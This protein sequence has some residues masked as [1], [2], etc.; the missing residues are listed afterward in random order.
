MCRVWGR[1]FFLFALIFV[2]LSPKGVLAYPSTF[3]GWYTEDNGRKIEPQGSKDSACQ[4]LLLLLIQTKALNNDPPYAPW[5]TKVVT[6]GDHYYCTEM[7]AVDDSTDQWGSRWSILSAIYKCDQPHSEFYYPNGKPTPDSPPDCKCVAPYFE[8]DGICV[9]HNIEI[10][11]PSITNALPSLVGPVLQTVT[12]DLGGEPAPGILVE[13]RSSRAGEMNF[14]SFTG[15]TDQN[16][17]FEFQY[18]PPFSQSVN[19]K[20]TAQCST[21]ENVASKNIRVLAVDF[22][23]YDSGESGGDASG[24]DDMGGNA[25]GGSGGNNNMCKR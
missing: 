3:V 24:G 11:G 4:A 18:V 14:T 13:V 6:A 23:D 22:D 12:V 10:D 19:I 20:L 5:T 8:K 7:S 9:A 25:G 15:V 16:G 1:M 21:C 17:E 2:L